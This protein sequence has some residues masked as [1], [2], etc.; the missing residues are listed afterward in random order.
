MNQLNQEKNINKIITAWSNFLN[1]EALYLPVLGPVYISG[2]P[3][4]KFLFD[5]L[6]NSQFGNFLPYDK[7]K[8]WHRNKTER[9]LLEE[10][11]YNDKELY[12][13]V[14]DTLKNTLKVFYYSN[15]SPDNV[16]ITKTKKFYTKI[17]NI[18]TLKNLYFY[19]FKEPRVETKFICQ[20]IYLKNITPKDSINKFF[21]GINYY[22]NLGDEVQFTF[23]NLA[24]E[25][26]LKHFGFLWKNFI[27]K[28][29]NL[30]PIIC[31]VFKNKI[32]G[33]IGPLDLS[34]DVYGIPFLFPSYF[35]VA[36]RMRKTG[37]GKKLW[38]SAMSFAYQK[39]AQYT[40]VQNAPDSPAAYFYE[41]QGLL[42]A[43]KIYYFPLSSD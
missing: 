31:A 3:I 9:V 26:G 7:N 20:N 21:K 34:K 2:N 6:N 35:G 10:I 17:K 19:C 11:I 23:S 12:I 42:K 18:Q 32:V 25:P 30:N 28:D 37:F 8:R 41:K 39:G 15:S 24:T 29:K 4:Q 33:A 36:D 5:I 40:L 27:V 38:K 22:D 16:T 43:N 1:E 14:K 13:P